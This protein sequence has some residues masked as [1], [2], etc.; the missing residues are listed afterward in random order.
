MKEE[1]TRVPKST[2]SCYPFHLTKVNAVSAK[3]M[4]GAWK[5]GF[6]ESQ[7]NCTR[8]KRTGTCL[9]LEVNMRDKIAPLPLIFVY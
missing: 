4:I 2:V 8:K 1:R 6:E 7:F 5:A 3:G 9:C